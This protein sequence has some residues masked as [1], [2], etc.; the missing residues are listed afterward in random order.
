MEFIIM[1]AA[2]FDLLIEKL[3]N[4]VNKV[5]GMYKG[6]DAILEEWLDNQDVCMI[7]NISPRTLQTLRDKDKI[8]YTKI[9]RKV[10]YKPKDVENFIHNHIKKITAI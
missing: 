4:L 3:N 5:S 10:Y 6:K 9:Q 2:L 7:L 1:D 8:P